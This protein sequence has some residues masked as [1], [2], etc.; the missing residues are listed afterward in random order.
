MVTTV[1]ARLLAVPVLALG[2]VPLAQGAGHPFPLRGR[3]DPNP[4]PA[5][6]TGIIRLASRPHVRCVVK[7]QTPGGAAGLLPGAVDTPFDGIAT[8]GFSPAAGVSSGIITGSCYDHAGQGGS[9]TFPFRVAP[10]VPPITT[11]LRVTTYI[12]PST[13][14]PGT[15]ATIWVK[16]QPGILCS[17]DITYDSGNPSRSF[18][19]YF[20]HVGPNGIVIWPWRVNSGK[21]TGATLIARCVHAATQVAAT[22]HF[23]IAPR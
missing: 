20:Q 7:V 17:A 8:W 21:E 18:D 9:T 16:T 11:R 4:I 15:P 1:L 23:A 6:S 10:P 12:T 13:V 5:G 19:G 3:L 22:S 2:A 14:S